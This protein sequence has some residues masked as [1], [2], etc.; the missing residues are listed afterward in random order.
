MP[1]ENGRPGMII[2]HST[3]AE[4]I[5]RMREDAAWWLGRC[6]CIYAD[7]VRAAIRFRHLMTRKD[8]ALHR[9]LT[10]GQS[11]PTGQAIELP[12]RGAES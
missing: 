7:R 3:D 5:I 8:P 12:W 6:A 11:G 4:V 2:R 1:P 9:G 10:W